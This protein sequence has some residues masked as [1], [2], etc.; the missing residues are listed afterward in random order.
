MSPKSILTCPICSSTYHRL[1]HLV[2][3]AKQKH[4]MDL[5]NY[6]GPHTFNML[7]TQINQNEVSDVESNKN[8]IEH[9]NSMQTEEII[10][11]KKSSQQSSKLNLIK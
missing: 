2:R 6:D 3:H 4:H 8:S 7:T 5:S 9:F 10:P 11:P 1:G